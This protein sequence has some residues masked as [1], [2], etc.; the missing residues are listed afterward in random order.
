MSAAVVPT[1][2]PSVSLAPTAD[3]HD[4]FDG[5]GMRCDLYDIT[6]CTSDFHSFL[7]WITIVGWFAFL[8]GL[9][10]LQLKWLLFEGM[11]PNIFKHKPNAPQIMVMSVPIAQVGEGTGSCAF[12]SEPDYLLTISQSLTSS[13]A[14]SV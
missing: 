4:D 1:A 5:P 7:L 8:C 13:P 14:L 9:R 10:E 3:A 12:L 6:G 11:K 2:A